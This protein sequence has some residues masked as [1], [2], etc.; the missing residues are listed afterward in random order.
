MADIEYEKDWYED[1]GGEEERIQAVCKNGWLVPSPAAALFLILEGKKLK[2]GDP[3]L[4]EIIE[5]LIDIINERYEEW[6]WTQK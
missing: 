3:R 5:E 4:T 2:N 6:K 1:I